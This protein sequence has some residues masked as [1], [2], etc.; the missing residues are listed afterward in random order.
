[1]PKAN[2]ISKINFESVSLT[3]ILNE[4]PN[5]AT[6]LPP[7]P[8]VPRDMRFSAD[9]P[10]MKAQEP[11]ATMPPPKNVPGTSVMQALQ[12]QSDQV[13]QNLEAWLDLHRSA[14]Q[15]DPNVMSKVSQL[16]PYVLKLIEMIRA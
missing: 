1:M 15:K 10:Q 9:E 5:D 14:G 4:A 2:S 12:K 8:R 3:K 16:E 7:P 6:R 11:G 13:A